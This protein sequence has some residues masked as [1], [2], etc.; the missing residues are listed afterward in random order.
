MPYAFDGTK[1]PEFE[2]APCG[3][4]ASWD[5][6]SECSYRCET[7]NAI[8]GSMG[9]PQRCHDIAKEKQDVAE[10]K[11]RMGFPHEA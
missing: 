7:C 9:M 10:V 5:Y 2:L 3:E 8:L 6:G 1:V 11:K 4:I